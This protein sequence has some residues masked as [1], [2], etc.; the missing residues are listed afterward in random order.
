MAD[1][2]SVEI[3]Y[4]QE[5]NF[6]ETPNNAFEK[7]RHTGGTF[8]VTTNTTRSSEVR[9]DAQRGGAVRTG[10]E[11]NATINMELSGRTFDDF[12]RD[13][14]RANSW[15]TAVDISG[16]DI[17]ADSTNDKFVSS[18]SVDFTTTNIV[19]GQWV[20]I[21][22]FADTQI[23][24]WYKATDVGQTTAGELLVAN[25]V[26]ADEASGESITMAGSYVRNGTNDPSYSLQ[27]QHL[28]L[29]DK[30][31]LIKGARIGQ[32]SLDFSTGSIITGS[33][34]FQAQSHELAASAAGDGTV[35]AAPDTEIMNAIDHITGIFIDDTL[36]SGEASAFSFQ[37]N[38]NA[39]RLNAIGQL[40]ASD[41]GL[42]SM[43]LTGSL[44]F[45]LDGDT[46]G[47]LQDYVD[48]AKFGLAIALDDGNGNGYVIEFP[49][50]V[51][52]N[53]PGNVPGPD[54][55]IQLQF[56]FSAEPGESYNK[57][58]QVTRLNSA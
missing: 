18:S 29:T 41:I 6:G 24:G 5:T 46:W 58:I 37:A 53:E 27:L 50:A 2:S 10:F 55:D 20:Y 15:S 47:Q 19:K 22:G 54:E 43:D 52:S 39:R 26:P 56:D 4:T 14:I 11:P 23:N 36:V 48:F 44:T 51:R 38:A 40:E 34:Q 21:D 8:G 57:T 3:S 33:F 32:F 25:S 13:A 45:Y 7:L 35:N 42:G 1:S 9:G 12:M 28:D 16:S 30:Y 49:K 17:S 31:K